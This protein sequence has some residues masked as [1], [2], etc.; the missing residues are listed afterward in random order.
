MKKWKYE[1]IFK[2]FCKFLRIFDIFICF[3]FICIEKLEENN[4]YIK[5]SSSSSSSSRRIISTYITDPLSP[6]FS[7]LHCFWQVFSTELLVV[8]PLLVHVKGSTGEHHLWVCP[9]FSSS[10]H[11]G[12][13]WRSK[14]KLIS[15]VWFV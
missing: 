6:P 4:V 14:D 2:K 12:H 11:A 3:I 7:I 8:L 15:D 13:C 10:V 1:I 9:Y 5:I